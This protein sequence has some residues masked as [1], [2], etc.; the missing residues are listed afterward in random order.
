M[1]NW[2][3]CWF[4]T[5]ILTKYTVQEAKSLVKNLVRQRCAEGFNSSVKGLKVKLSLLKFKGLCSFLEKEIVY[6]SIFEFCPS[7]SAN[8]AARNWMLCWRQSLSRDVRSMKRTNIDPA[9]HLG[10]ST[11]RS[12]LHCNQKTG[13][14]ILSTCGTQL[15][16]V[17]PERPWIQYITFV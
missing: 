9:N 11:V 5:H 17:C 6:L 3:I 14:H 4:F 13:C 1:N 8:R 15:S 12:V 7:V 2:C 16:P 10:H